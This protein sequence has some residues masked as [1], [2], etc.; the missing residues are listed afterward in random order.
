[1]R[2][3]IITK[4]TMHNNALISHITTTDA[5]CIA[6]VL[7]VR[8][9]HISHAVVWPPYREAV[10]IVRGLQLRSRDPTTPR[11]KIISR[12][13]L[14]T[15]VCSVPPLLQTVIPRGIVAIQ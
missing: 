5:S 4:Y 1:M 11:S 15:H 2:Y 7:T 10:L 12:R 9:H 6:V 13:S 14:H 3:T 8:K